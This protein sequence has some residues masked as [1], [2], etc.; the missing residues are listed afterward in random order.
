MSS[1]EN[2]CVFFENRVWI[3]KINRPYLH[4]VFRKRKRNRKVSVFSTRKK[5]TSRPIRLAVRTRP[6]HG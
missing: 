3:F 2:S 1:F 5:G 6:F 4:H